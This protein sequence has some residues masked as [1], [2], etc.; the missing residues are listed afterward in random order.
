M[1]SGSRRRTPIA[2][3]VSA[4]YMSTIPT[5]PTIEQL[6]SEFAASDL[7]GWIWP[8][9]TGVLAHYVRGRLAGRYR[10]SLYSPSG[11]WDEEGISDL[12]SE[13]IIERGIKRGGVLAAFQRAESV[14][15]WVAYIERSFHHFAVSE[16]AR[17][18]ATNIFDR[19]RDV[20]D[21]DTEYR[22][23]AGKGSRAAYGLHE[24]AESPPP[25]ATDLDL[26]GIERHLPTGIRWVNYETG[27]RQSPGIATEDLRRIAHAVLAGAARL[28]TA[29]QI[30]QII[31]A[32]F[33]LSRDG[34]PVGDGEIV[35]SLPASAPDPL[36]ETVAADLARRA[37]SALSER[38]RT[39]LRLMLNEH[40]PLS[41]REVAARLKIGKSLVNNEQRAIANQLRRLHVGGRGE[42]SQVLCAM[43]RIL[44]EDGRSALG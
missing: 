43:E 23:L 18:V 3:T 37:L 36:E 29:D 10:A 17:T 8:W 41:V 30:M 7:R 5:N 9:L 31:E 32:R 33:G 39:I 19:L 40:P 25:A 11:Q 13:F 4:R 21:K 38:Q 44:H 34:T 14:A 42:Q 26:R 35:A 12:I 2:G 16:R 1:A 28:M 24:W 20:L 27:A 6:H 15:G 22:R